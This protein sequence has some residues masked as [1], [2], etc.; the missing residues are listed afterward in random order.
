MASIFERLLKSVLSLVLVGL[1]VPVAVSG[2]DGPHD[3]WFFQGDSIPVPPR[4]K[5]PWTAPRVDIPADYVSVL[6]AAFERGLSDPRG[7]E[8]REV[9]APVGSDSFGGFRRQKTHGWLLPESGRGSQRFAILWNGVVCPVISVGSAASVEADL[10]RFIAYYAQ[11]NALRED[12]TSVSG[13]ERPAYP[14]VFPEELCSSGTV[15]ALLLRL[16]EAKLAGEVYHTVIEQYNDISRFWHGDVQKFAPWALFSRALAAH[17]YGDDK[18]ALCYAE[19]YEPWLKD[20]KFEFVP[21]AGKLLAEQRRRARPRPVAKNRIDALIQDLENVNLRQCSQPGGICL[22]YDKR[23]RDLVTA[24]GAAVEPLLECLENDRRLTRSVRF[25]RDFHPERTV[26]TVAEAAYVALCGILQQSFSYSES[27]SG[28]MSAHDMEF[29]RE[30]ARRIR[31]HCFRYQGLSNEEKWYRILLNDDEPPE[32]QLQA[33]ENICR[34]GRVG[35]MAYYNDSSATAAES[36]SAAAPPAGELLRTKSNPSVSE[37][38]NRRAEEYLSDDKTAAAPPWIFDKARRMALFSAEWNL[39]DSLPALRKVG[40]AVYR[41]LSKHEYLES[42]WLEAL[43][44]LTIRRVDA[45]DKAALSQYCM[46]LL[47]AP[48]RIWME[49]GETWSCYWEPLYTFPEEPVSVAAAEEIFHA[50]GKARSEYFGK[51]GDAGLSCG[52]FEKLM[53]LAPYRMHVR[54][55]LGDKTGIM[56]LQTTFSGDSAMLRS[57]KFGGGRGCT[58]LPADCVKND[59]LFPGDGTV[60][61]LRICDVYAE[62]LF[63]LKNGGYP[64]FRRYW[65][66]KERDRAIGKILLLLSQRSE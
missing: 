62:A 17:M 15:C 31:A 40:D 11:L 50:S 58:S 3:I 19:Q 37:L 36:G 2:A 23:I 5:E 18:L 65:N 61:V 4:Q 43:A 28:G 12:E 25:H 6:A 46:A 38:L 39:P 66:E 29:R 59:P 27:I 53:R 1:C 45:G 57:V 7:C 56:K 22:E 55:G 8:Y 26:I 64:E 63:K 52:L 44:A 24:G 9:T 49:G 35:A 30:I 20:D 60:Q 21:A 42:G 54:N 16:G 51:F 13:Q 14:E 47:A 33:A 48:E 41:L 32:A 10:R 34:G